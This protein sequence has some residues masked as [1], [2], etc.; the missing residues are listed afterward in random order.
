MVFVC[1]LIRLIFFYLRLLHADQQVSELPGQ[2]EPPASLLHDAV[3][4]CSPLTLDCGATLPEELS[5][6][7]SPPRR[8]LWQTR[9]GLCLPGCHTV[10]VISAHRLPIYMLFYSLPFQDKHWLLR[11]PAN[12]MKNSSLDFLDNAYKKRYNCITFVKLF[13]LVWFWI[14]ILAS[15]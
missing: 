14:Q 1:K 11:Q 12:P 7:Q 8:K 13:L 15:H 10:S 5:W 3:P 2:Q 6:H 9:K 4:S